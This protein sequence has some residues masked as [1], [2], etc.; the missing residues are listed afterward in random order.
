MIDYTRVYHHGVRVPDIDAAMAEV[1]VA[2]GLTWC[3]PQVRAQ[4]VAGRR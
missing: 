3:E 4:V 1:G 2:L